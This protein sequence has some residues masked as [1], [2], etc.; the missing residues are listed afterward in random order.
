MERNFW[1]LSKER[2]RERERDPCNAKRSADRVANI[3]A[4]LVGRQ[5][6]QGQMPCV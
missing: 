3:R 6:L 4:T 2:E 1:L 5:A